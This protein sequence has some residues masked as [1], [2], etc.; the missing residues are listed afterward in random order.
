MM[1]PQPHI[2]ELWKTVPKRRT[3][4]PFLLRNSDVFAP[5]TPSSSNQYPLATWY[6]IPRLI[7][8]ITV[9]IHKW[10]SPQ[11]EVPLVIIHFDGSFPYKPSI[12]GYHAFIETSKVQ[13]DLTVYRHASG[14]DSGLVR[15]FSKKTKMTRDENK[16]ENVKKHMNKKKIHENK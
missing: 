6:N 16:Q 9:G 15:F 3:Y 13:Q 8:S 7:N 5:N 2:P 14:L 10:G 12:L 1:Y 11:M 4:K